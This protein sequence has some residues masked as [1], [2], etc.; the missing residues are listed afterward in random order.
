M[1]LNKIKEI[2]K[3]L[4]FAKRAFTKGGFRHVTNYISGLIASAK[5]TV[6][7]IAK[8]CPDE[9]YPSALS[10]LL[11]E[12]KFEKELLEQ[13]YLKKIR[14][15]FKNYQVLLLIDDTIVERNGEHIQEAQ[16][17]FDHTTNSYVRGHQFFT[18]ILYTNFMQLPLF[19][20][21]YS[22]STD[23]KIEMAKDIIIKIK[24]AKIKVD[25][26]LFDSWYSDRKLIKTCIRARM[27][28]IC[29]IKSNRK[30]K[31]FKQKT[32]NALSS[33]SKKIRLQKL[34]ECKRGGKIYDVWSEQTYLNKLPL[35]RLVISHER[36]D[37]KIQDRAINL[38]STNTKDTIQDI[39]ETYKIRWRI[40]TYHRDIKQNLGF[41]K[42][43][44]VNKEAVVR[45]SILVS[46][47]YATLSL[48]MYM[49]GEVMTIGT[50]CE[51]LQNKSEHDLLEEI[52]AIEDAPTRVHRFEEVFIT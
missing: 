13:R 2:V 49:K 47:A 39:L 31:L 6:K 23:S 46:I 28:V 48:F 8:A 33:F 44:F 25:T 4:N 26:V 1:V 32:W 40:E 15:L 45:H 38:I 36:V 27:R 22:N 29:G 52:I 3:V 19:P 5:K 37:G 12:A 50:C 41:A 21:L 11:N 20:E 18:S 42:V 51:Y 7:K 43:F 14:Y 16:K 30:I 35:M 10:R 17:H 34:Q 9:K 24:E